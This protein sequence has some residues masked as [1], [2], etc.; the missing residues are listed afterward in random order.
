MQKYKCIIVEDEPIA[1]EVLQD[2][3]AQISFLDLRGTCRDAIYAME[4]MQKEKIDVIFLDIHLPKLKGFDFIRTLKDP[5]RI[6]ITSAYQE[7]ALEGYELNVIDYLLKPVEFSRFL[8]AVNKLRHHEL[9]QHA[10][11]YLFF[12]VSKKQVKVYIDEILYIESVRE[13]I[14]IT[15]RDKT[16]LTKMQLGEIEDALPKGSFIRVHRSFIVSKSKIESYSPSEI[17]IAGTK[18]PIGRN[19]K[20]LILLALQF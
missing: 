12:N 6:I 2:Y 5:P 3:I 7:Y 14:R 20:E 18:I 8:A 1:A 17:E 9:P 11:P 10:N 19:Y 13:Y 15:T 16:I 4:L